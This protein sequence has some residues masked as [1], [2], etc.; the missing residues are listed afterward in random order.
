MLHLHL[1]LHVLQRRVHGLLGGCH[2]QFRHVCR[3]AG[4]VCHPF[5]RAPGRPLAAVRPSVVSHSAVVSGAVCRTAGHRCGHVVSCIGGNNTPRPTIW[6]IVPTLSI[7]RSTCLQPEL[8]TTSNA[9]NTP[10]NSA[11]CWLITHYGHLRMMGPY[12]LHTPTKAPPG[13]QG[14]AAAFVYTRIAGPSVGCGSHLQKAPIHGKRNTMRRGG[15]PGEAM[16]VP[17]RGSTLPRSLG[18]PTTQYAL[19]VAAGACAC[20]GTG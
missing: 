18:V 9:Q 4:G 17:P 19:A 14:Q 15:V 7:T 8:R 5:T 12:E 2:C 20:S 16:R 3:R 6:A 10:N 1:H 13:A 11:D